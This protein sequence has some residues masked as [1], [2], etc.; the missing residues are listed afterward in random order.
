[1]DKPDNINE[2]RLDAAGDMTADDM[3]DIFADSED[4][5]GSGEAGE[6]E[7][8]GGAGQ[9]DSDSG[10]DSDANDTSEDD[11][12]GADGDEPGD[13]ESEE[14]SDEDEGEDEGESEEDAE[15][16]EPDGDSGDEQ[17]SDDAA[18]EP[19]EADEESVKT[20]EQY[21]SEAIKEAEQRYGE[22]ALNSAIK[23]VAQ[24]FAPQA[25][26]VKD[27]LAKAEAEL[28]AM[29]KKFT[30]P[31]ED[32][33]IPEQTFAER[34]RERELDRIIFQ[35]KD[36][37]E[38]IVNNIGLEADKV[39]EDL[40]TKRAA[41]EAEAT[42]QSNLKAYPKLAAV[43]EGFREAMRRGLTFESAAEAVEVSA[44][45]MRAKG[46]TVAKPKPAPAKPKAGELEKA[47]LESSLARKKKGAMTAGN[48]SSGAKGAPAKENSY[49][50]LSHEG[51]AM[52]RY[53]DDML[54]ED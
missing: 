22:E 42:I 52:A 45:L 33:Y 40:K 27:T 11:A 38:Q 53:F 30:T 6:S 23:S 26:V 37:W 34:R 4:S 19:E 44:A 51:R 47:A 54:K 35:A 48:G 50:G 1:M 14:D 41:A 29:E 13:E 46:K 36:K 8:D 12:E 3:A 20:A 24:K 18:D 7:P 15:G 10:S 49:K 43:E 16:D 31:D 21:Y 5:P 32:G 17:E 2:E 39:S 28:A 25:Q 9:G